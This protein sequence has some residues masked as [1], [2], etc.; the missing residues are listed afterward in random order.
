MA[1][2]YI[3]KDLRG[4]GRILMIFTTKSL[5]TTAIFGGIGV[6]MYFLFSLLGLKIVGVIVLAL[7]ALL[8]F[9][10]GTFKMPKITGLRF[11]KNIEGDSMDE[12]LIRFIKFKS[13]R[14]IYS[15][16]KEDK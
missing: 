11:T 1:T 2:H 13:N 4:E 10:F 14:K 16:T 12:I 7:L 6:V 9:A 5:I 8:G 15:Y 3:P